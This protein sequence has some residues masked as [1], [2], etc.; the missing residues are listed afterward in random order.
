MTDKNNSPALSVR[1]TSA[2]YVVE[3]GAAA[4]EH[5]DFARL[6]LHDASSLGRAGVIHLL[7]QHNADATARS[8]SN[9]L[10]LHHAS[11]YQAT[12][13]GYIEVV[14]ILFGHSLLG[15]VRPDRSDQTISKP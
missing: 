15:I 5:Y 11:L 14:Q 9:E 6:L 7:L 3:Y 13:H 2:F 4:D 8:S 1:W 12:E 10:P